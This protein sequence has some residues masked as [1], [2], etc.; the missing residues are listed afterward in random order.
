MLELPP[1]PMTTNQAL[2]ATIRDS[3]PDSLEWTEADRAL[4]QL[5]MSQAAD[6]D[7][8]EERDDLAGVRERRFA[9]LALARLVG[10]LDLPHHAR[11]SVL[12]ARKAAAARWGQDAAG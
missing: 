10:Q 3:L 12:K 9:R 5:A 4:L 7:R 11:G 1:E 6:L 8:L 2:I